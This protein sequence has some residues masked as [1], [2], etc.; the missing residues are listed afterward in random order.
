MGG[1]P[2]QTF[3]IPEQIWKQFIEKC[4]GKNSNASEVLRDFIEGVVS[5]KISLESIIGRKKS[6]DLSDFEEAAKTWFQ[7]Q[8]IDS[9]G[10]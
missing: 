8:H 4:K 7:T 2:R 9:E 5:G 6:K 1:T 10:T 3:R